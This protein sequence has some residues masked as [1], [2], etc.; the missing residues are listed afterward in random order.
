MYE[1]AE[2]VPRGSIGASLRAGVGGPALDPFV[3]P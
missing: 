1:A 2:P 3:G